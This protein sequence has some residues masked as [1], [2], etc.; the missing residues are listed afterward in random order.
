MAIVLDHHYSS[1]ASILI[2]WYEFA[3]DYKKLLRITYFNPHLVRLLLIMK[4]AGEI[5]LYNWW[6]DNNGRIPPST[7]ARPFE[8]ERHCWRWIK[9]RRPRK[10]K[11]ADEIR[12]RRWW[13][14]SDYPFSIVVEAIALIDASCD[15]YSILWVFEYMYGLYLW[16]LEM[17]DTSWKHIFKIFM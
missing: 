12:R 5:V 6:T 11:S 17:K 1:R 8:W 2:S 3:K 10:T 14:T 15:F 9:C 4:R 16:R 13:W 7:T